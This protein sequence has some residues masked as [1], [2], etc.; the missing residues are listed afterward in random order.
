MPRKAPSV[1]GG[2]WWGADYAVG[3]VAHIHEDA[4]P[5]D[6]VVFSVRLVMPQ[7]MAGP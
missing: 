3:I 2:A 1:S 4:P 7:D 6:I 5:G